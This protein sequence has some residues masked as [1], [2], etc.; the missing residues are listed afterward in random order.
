MGRVDAAVRGRRIRCHVGAHD[1]DGRVRR[2]AP[3]RA[4][5]AWSGEPVT[6]EWAM[7]TAGFPPPP[8]STEPEPTRA[9]GTAIDADDAFASPDPVGRSVADPAVSQAGTGPVR[10][11]LPA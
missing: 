4:R 2:D 5:A 3:A 7:P 8:V 9:S 1:G 10:A 11:S 6:A